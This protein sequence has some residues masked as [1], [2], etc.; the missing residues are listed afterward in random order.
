VLVELDREVQ[1]VEVTVEGEGLNVG[2]IEETIDGLGGTVHSVDLVAC[3]ERLVAPRRPDR[4][5]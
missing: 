1:N 5:A 3:G 4:D 2:A